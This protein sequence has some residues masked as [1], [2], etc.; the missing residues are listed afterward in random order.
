MREE[1]LIIVILENDTNIPI[2]REEHLVEF[3]LTLDGYE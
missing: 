3:H 2:F 1:R